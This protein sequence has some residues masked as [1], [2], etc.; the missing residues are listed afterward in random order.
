MLMLVLWWKGYEKSN[1]VG[2]QPHKKN[3]HEDSRENTRI[4]V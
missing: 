4:W 2:L 3:V 1:V